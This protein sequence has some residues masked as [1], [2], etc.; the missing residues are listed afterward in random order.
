MEGV[1]E[2]VVYADVVFLLNSC[3]DFLLLWLTSG[4]RKEQVTFWRLLLASI[5]GGI[6]ATL[7]LWPMFTLAY[8]LPMK[9]LSSLFMVWIVFGY[10]HP[11]IFLRTLGVFY[12]VCFVTGGTMVALHYIVEGDAQVA[13]G[14]LFT[15]TKGWGSPVSWM[16]ISFGFPLVWLYTKFTFQSMKEREQVEQ[17]MTAV[18]IQISGKS[19]EC[20][21]LVDTG[22]QLRDP[23]SR[24]PVMLVELDQLADYLPAEVH[25]MFR[26]QDWE[27][28]WSEIP[29]EW[30]VKIRIIPY[31]AARSDSDMMIAF[32]PDQVE[33]WQDDQW[34]TAGKVLIGIDVGQL[35]A[36]GSYQAIIHPSC[37]SVVS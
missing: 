27:Q 5:V 4:I 2:L 20:M 26:N 7:Y 35:S 12:F 30:M 15:E 19:F 14:I 16:F 23:I 13:G 8:T 32:K 36:D 31:R 21:G 25:K 18:K 6:Y 29:P 3:I 24:A 28:S 11:L 22:N 17:Y 9:L 33:I 37:I 34:N 1:G 10:R